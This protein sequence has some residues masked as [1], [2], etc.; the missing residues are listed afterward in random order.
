MFTIFQRIEINGKLFP[1][2]FYPLCFEIFEILFI[3][4]FFFFYTN[5]SQCQL[6]IKCKLVEAVIVLIIRFKKKNLIIKRLSLLKSNRI[7]MEGKLIKTLNGIRGGRT[8]I[9]TKKYFPIHRRYLNWKT[10][11]LA[12]GKWVD[13]FVKSFINNSCEKKSLPGL[14][15]RW[16]NA[17][18]VMNSLILWVYGRML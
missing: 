7:Q 9:L 16:N 5:K 17:K 11:T 14:I 4:F 8:E 6:A 3:V 18:L 2:Y 1:L 15:V 12:T 13:C 10:F